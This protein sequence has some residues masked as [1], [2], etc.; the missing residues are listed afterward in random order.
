MFF[1]I[2]LQVAMAAAVIVLSAFFGKAAMISA[3]AGAAVAIVP[4]MIF[5]LYLKI[6]GKPSV[7]RFFIGEAAK[8]AVMIYISLL[9]WRTYG[10][11]VNALAYWAA[12]IVVIKA[13]NLSLLRTTS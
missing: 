7:V 6:M 13:H 3:V 8:V 5:A 12:L 10:S 4:N 1:A 2:G 9:V 11:D